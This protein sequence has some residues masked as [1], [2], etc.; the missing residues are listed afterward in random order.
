MPGPFWEPS[1]KPA[2]HGYLKFVD[3][4]NAGYDV[5]ATFQK[6]KKVHVSIYAQGDV[7][8]KLSAN[9]W[10]NVTVTGLDLDFSDFFVIKHKVSPNS[11]FPK[12]DGYPNYQ[13]FFLAKCNEQ[14]VSLMLGGP[15]P[16]QQA[17]VRKIVQ[18]DFPG[19][20]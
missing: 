5:H 14:Y 11:D 6:D 9:I 7:N 16:K 12:V 8:T 13:A 18:S 17:I 3:F 10:M 15:K 19:L 2:F 20:G 4:Q 1:T